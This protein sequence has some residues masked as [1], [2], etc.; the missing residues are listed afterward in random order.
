MK[1]HDESVVSKAFPGLTYRRKIDK[2]YI[3]NMKSSK[4]R[5]IKTLS[6]LRVIMPI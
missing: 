3:Q 1:I 2:Q 4:R 5:R 6:F